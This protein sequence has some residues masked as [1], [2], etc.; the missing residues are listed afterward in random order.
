ALFQRAKNG[1]GPANL[2]EILLVEDSESDMELTLHAFKMAKIANPIHIVRD[3][4]AALEFLFHAGH[5]D[6]W[7]ERKPLVV[8]LDLALPKVG[9]M[10]V[11][12]RLKADRRTR[13]IPVI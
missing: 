7:S 6:E 1:G 3:G 4:A 11:L 5:V 2:V 10:E 8:L 9:G 12:R 13:M